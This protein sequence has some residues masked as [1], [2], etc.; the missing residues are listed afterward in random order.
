[1]GGGIG[2]GKSGGLMM[3]RRLD[4]IVPRRLGSFTQLSYADCSKA[5]R[6]IRPAVHVRLFL[7]L[8]YIDLL[9]MAPIALG[10]LR[11]SNQASYLSDPSSKLP[12]NLALLAPYLFRSFDYIPNLSISNAFSA[13]PFQT[14]AYLRLLLLNLDVNLL[15]D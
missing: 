7:N 8:Q 2:L 1:M 11:P 14:Q 12:P 4:P 3:E 13:T 10:P 15:L 9:L 6:Y 5:R